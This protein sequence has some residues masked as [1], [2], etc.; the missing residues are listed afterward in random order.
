MLE[1]TEDVY[2]C[3]VIISVVRYGNSEW[4]IYSGNNSVISWNTEILY[5]LTY[6]IVS[7]YRK[8]P[9]KRYII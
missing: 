6:Y 5:E 4:Q 2:G 3:G 7:G 9:Q 8:S 1:E